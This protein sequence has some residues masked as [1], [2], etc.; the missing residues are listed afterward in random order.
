M[1]LRYISRS[2][3]IPEVFKGV[4]AVLI[5]VALLSMAFTGISGKPLSL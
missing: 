3:T 2:R 5:Y 1:G 4:P